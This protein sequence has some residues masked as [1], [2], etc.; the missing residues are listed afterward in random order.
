M[1]PKPR[2]EHSGSRGEKRER[3]RGRTAIALVGFYPK[4]PRGP[5]RGAK[6]FPSPEFGEEIWHIESENKDD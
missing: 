4:R 6:R 1:S 2:A 3:E 5:A